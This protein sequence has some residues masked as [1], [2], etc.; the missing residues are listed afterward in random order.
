MR[1]FGFCF[2]QESCDETLAR[3]SLARVWI[4]Q[5][6]QGRSPS[7]DL[8]KLLPFPA[9]QVRDLRVCRVATAVEKV[10]WS[11]PSG[12]IWTARPVCM[13]RDHLPSLIEIP[14]VIQNGTDCFL[15]HPSDLGCQFRTDRLGTEFLE[16]INVRLFLRHRELLWL[17]E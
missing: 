5:A 2:N 4:L 17:M 10:P 8:R 15:L 1:G 14:P 12:L 13:R 3:A 16:P 7:T 9:E 6:W 11:L